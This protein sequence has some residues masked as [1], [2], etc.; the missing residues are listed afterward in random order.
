M[1]QNNCQCR[2]TF[3]AELPFKTKDFSVKQNLRELINTR[4]ETQEF[5]MCV[6]QEE[7]MLRIQGRTSKENGTRGKKGKCLL[8]V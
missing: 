5:L 6:F 1:K 3:P 8:I 7:G 4:L 2:I